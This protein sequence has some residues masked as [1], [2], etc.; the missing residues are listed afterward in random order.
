MAINDGGAVYPSRA[1]WQSWSDAD[2]VRQYEVMD[3]AR[4]ISLRDHFAGEAIR[5][6]ADAICDSLSDGDEAH[7][8]AHA[9][10]HAKAAYLLADAMLRAREQ[11]G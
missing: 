9:E 8:R 11:E 7:A 10:R 3:A 1:G 5:G 6:A 2:G 4:G